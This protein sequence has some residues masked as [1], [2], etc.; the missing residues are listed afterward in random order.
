MKL[1]KDE[2]GEPFVKLDLYQ[3]FIVY[4]NEEVID[5]YNRICDH[6]GGRLCSHN[7]KIV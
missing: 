1:H 2:N 4:K 3:D 6:N 5:I 7:K